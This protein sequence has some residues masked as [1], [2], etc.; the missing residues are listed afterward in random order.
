M[1]RIWLWGPLYYK[2][3]KEPPQNSI[4]DDLGPYIKHH[5]VLLNI[6]IVIIEVIFVNLRHLYRRS[7]SSS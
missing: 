5:V 2:H 6:I 3:K 1:I 7:R 4:G